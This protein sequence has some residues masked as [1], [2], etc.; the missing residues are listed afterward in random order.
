MQKLPTPERNDSPG[1]SS[2]GTPADRVRARA[3]AALIG[4][5]RRHPLVVFFGLAFVLSWW[6]AV[7]YAFGALPSPIAGFGPFLAAVVV[8]A[9]TEGR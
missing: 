8:R 9:A 6:P 4:V 5:V 7:F 1:P 3:P 2:P